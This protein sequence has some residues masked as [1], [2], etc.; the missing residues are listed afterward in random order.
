MQRCV[1][2]AIWPKP[3]RTIQK[4]L[5]EDCAEDPRHRLLHRSIFDRADAD[6]AAF[7]VP[8][9]YVDPSNYWRSV[10]PTLQPFI[11]VPQ[12]LVQIRCVIL[13][14]LSIYPWCR[15]LTQGTE[16]QT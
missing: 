16:G 12:A 1:R 13:V 15:L 2:T 14:A 4:V 6:R 3:V 5:V 8:L 11:H 9:G 10:A 7:S